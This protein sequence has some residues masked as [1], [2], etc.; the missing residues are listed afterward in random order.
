MRRLSFLLT[1]MLALPTAAAEP[2]G[3]HLFKLKCAACH[4]PQGQGAKKYNKPLEG[5]RSVAQLS[6][7]IFDTMPESNPGSLSEPEA[8]AV[9]AYIYDAF[10]SPIARERNRP[11]RVEL[12]RL[13]VK[14]YR[15]AV[16]DVVAS[17]RKPITWG[18]PNGLKG[19]YYAGRRLGGRGGAALERLDPQVEFDFK[20]DTP[21]KDKIEPHEFSIRWTGSL[22]AP[23][24]G[25]YEFVIRTDHAARLWVN[26]TRKTLIDA[27][28]KSGNDT[29]YRGTI[30]LVAGRAYP[31]RLEFTKAKQGVDDSK[32]QKEKPKPQPAQ[33]ALLWKRPRQVPEPI[34]S[35]NLSPVVVPESYVCS[36]PF[37]PDDRSYGWER[38]TTVSKE[39][40]SATTDAALDAAGYVALH[41]EEL[42]GVKPAELVPASPD[43]GNPASINLDAKPAPKPSPEREKKLRD[44]A[45]TFTERAWRR[46]LTSEQQALV[47]RQFTATKDPEIGVKRVVMLAM[48]SPR[49]LYRELGGDGY[50][51]AARLSFGLWDSGPDAELLSAAAAGKLSTKE[52][53]ARQAERMLADPRAKAKLRA[54]LMNWAKAEHGLDL[55]KDTKKYPGFDAAVIADLH[56]SLELF[57]DEV[58]WSDKSDYRQLLLSD[59]LYLNRRLA[60]FYGVDLPVAKFYG[61]DLPAHADYVKVKLDAG[62]RAGVVTHPYLMTSFAHSS[63]SSPIHRGVFL[64][65]GVLGLSLRP[66]PEAVAPLPPELH[67]DLTTRERVAMQTKDNNC[68]TCHGIINPLGFTL[69]NF[70]A[71]GK[72]RDLDHGKPVDPTGS[73]RTRDGGTVTLKGAR[74]LANFVATS[75]EAQEAFVEQMF[76]HLAQ[77]PARAYGPATLDELRK[78]FAASGFNIRKLAVEIMA[79]SALTGRHIAPGLPGEKRASP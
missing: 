18:G 60:K 65:R 73:Y 52:Q 46:P 23:D 2:D 20:A 43:T 45:R 16:A 1:M 8:K 79:A 28:V 72:F 36:T 4:G 39:W 41:L 54:G 68:M 51:V 47:E 27:W 70:D 25:E 61:I 22:L 15:Q 14:Q 32:K 76:H 13:T 37:P 57:V 3:A 26:D 33:V 11:A 75:P 42:T 5:S 78:N 48:M 10:Y 24:T 7:L 30:F 44:F 74:D 31:L 53:V 77:Q 19:E 29:E 55:A 9:A 50:D 35:R 6:K 63:E 59:E 12:A 17:F 38:G 58:L 64:A 69:E 67:P 71:V 56:T 49:F 21:V 40:E 34:P 62:K 66:P